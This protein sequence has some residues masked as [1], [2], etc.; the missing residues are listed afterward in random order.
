MN[1]TEDDEITADELTE[2]ELR[3]VAGESSS[4]GGGGV[5]GLLTGPIFPFFPL[6]ILHYKLIFF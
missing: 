1:K 5:E 4:L 2:E 6:K 3:Q